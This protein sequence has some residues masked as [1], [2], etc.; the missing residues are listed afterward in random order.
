MDDELTVSMICFVGVLRYER[1]IS[2]AIG[3]RQCLGFIQRLSINMKISTS[4][5]Q[6]ASYFSPYPSAPFLLLFFF[7]LLFLGLIIATGALPILGLR[8]GKL[9]VENAQSCTGKSE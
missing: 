1:V 7:F 4:L 6:R 2:R 9:A 3:H 5:K 8:L